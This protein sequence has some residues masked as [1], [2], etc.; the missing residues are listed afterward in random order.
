MKMC[1]LF[2]FWKKKGERILLFISY[3]YIYI[4]KRYFNFKSNEI[5]NG[6]NSVWQCPVNMYIQKT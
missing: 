5:N 4:Y 6:F 1:D 2:I 3:S